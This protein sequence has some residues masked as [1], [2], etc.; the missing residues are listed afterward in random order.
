MAD[1]PTLPRFP[2]VS[3]NPGTQSFNNTRKRGRDGSYDSAQ[4]QLFANSS[5]PAMFSSDDDPSLENYTQGRHR[6]KRYVGSWFQQQPASGDSAFSEEVRPPKPKGKRTFQRQVDSGVWMGSDASTDLELE[7]P[8]PIPTTSRLPQLNMSRQTAAISEAEELVRDKVFDALENGDE[9]IDLTSMNIRQLSNATIAPLSD[10][11]P[12]PTV[13]PGVPFEQKDAALKIYLGQN[14]LT[15]V[16]G[17]VFNLEFLTYLSLRNGK[18]TE[19]PPAIGKLRNLKTLNISLN[20]LRS[21]P[22]ELLDLMTYPSKLKELMINPNPFVLPLQNSVI[23]LEGETTEWE[24]PEHALLLGERLWDEGRTVSKIWLDRREGLCNDTEYPELH[25][26]RNWTWRAKIIARTPIQFE[27]SR[28]FNISKHA[29]PESWLSTETVLP[30]ENLAEPPALPLARVASTKTC[31]ASRVP[32]LMELALKSCSRTSQLPQLPSYLPD[33]APS[34]LP[35]L[36]RRIAT[37]ADANSNAGD[38]PCSRCQRRVIV[39]AAQWIEWWNYGKINIDE[40][41]SQPSY[42]MDSHGVVPFLKRACSYRCLPGATQ[43]GTLL[44]ETLRFSIMAPE[45]L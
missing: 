5:D 32:S 24:G 27:D 9:D 4:A 22:S 31:N 6:K 8:F 44:P 30:T 41:S 1:E 18:L 25:D 29:L 42:A 23:E 38:L 21:L 7:D 37:Q 40:A 14:P 16:P 19:I 26:K 2:A 34:H 10:L 13:T 28:G 17:A 20:R 45:N 39:P 33:D 11:T 3:W 12:I 15:K 43:P 36:L 35:D